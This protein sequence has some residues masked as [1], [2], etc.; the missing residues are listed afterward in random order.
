MKDDFGS[1]IKIYTATHDDNGIGLIK[2]IASL[3]F[4]T[5]E[6][7]HTIFTAGN[8]GS[9]S[10]ASHFAAELVGRF[11]PGNRKALRAVSL[12]SDTTVLTAIG[13]DFGFEKIFSRQIE[14]LGKDGDLVICL[15]TSGRSSNIVDLIASSQKIGIKTVLLTG[16]HNEADLPTCDLLFKVNT[17][18]TALIQEVHL[19]IIHMICSYLEDLCQKGKP[20]VESGGFIYLKDLEKKEVLE[21]NLVWVNGCFD[22]LH[23]GHISFLREAASLGNKLWVGINSDK[24]IRGLKGEDRPIQSQELRAETLLVLPWVDRVVIFDE[25]EPTQAISKAKPQIVAKS[26]DYMNV[27]IPESGIIAELG[28]E[29]KYIK[30]IEGISSSDIITKIST[31]RK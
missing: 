18:S 10:E 3:I 26:S 29:I 25:P 28:I 9:A 30:K 24:S 11:L 31:V 20:E 27:T 14:A 1:R 23:K 13:N 15:S 4:N 5:L 2:Q 6:S 16:N 17:S 7:G 21:P 22:I 8:G 19:S 12:N